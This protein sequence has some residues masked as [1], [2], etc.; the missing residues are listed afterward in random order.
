MGLW[1]VFVDY[2]IL[3]IHQRIQGTEVNTGIHECENKQLSFCEA[4]F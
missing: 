2:F 3:Q 4:Y 1:S